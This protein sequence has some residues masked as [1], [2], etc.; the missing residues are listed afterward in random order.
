[1]CPYVAESNKTLHSPGS[2]SAKLELIHISAAVN[3]KTVLANLF[4][5]L[6]F[7]YLNKN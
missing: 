1:M 5:G 4:E 6:L 2:Q 7:V 3:F